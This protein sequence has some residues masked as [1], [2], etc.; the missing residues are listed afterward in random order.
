MQGGSG[1]AREQFF[2]CKKLRLEMEQPTLEVEAM[3]GN[4]KPHRDIL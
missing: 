4:V 2:G 1:G 3:V